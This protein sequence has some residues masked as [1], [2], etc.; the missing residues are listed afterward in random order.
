MLFSTLCLTKLYISFEVQLEYHFLSDVF[1]SLPAYSVTHFL[2]SHPAITVPT[3]HYRS[4]SNSVGIRIPWGSLL[5]QISC[6][7]QDFDLETDSGAYEFLTSSQM[8]LMLPV[9]GP[10]C[11][12]AQYGSFCMQLAPVRLKAEQATSASTQ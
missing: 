9:R 11:R 8:L 4:A 6:P 5:K 1:P 10:H 3:P 7:S 2:H 12:V